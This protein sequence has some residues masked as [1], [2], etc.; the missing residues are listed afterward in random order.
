[1]VFGVKDA[2]TPANTARV[3]SKVRRLTRGS[4]QYQAPPPCADQAS[5]RGKRV[6]A[7]VAG[8]LRRRVLAH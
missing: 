4:V 6:R 1:M 8:A 3:R 5:R 2:N 7:F